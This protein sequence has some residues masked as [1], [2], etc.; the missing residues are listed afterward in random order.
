MLQPDIPVWYRFLEI[1]GILFKN[2]W[3]DVLLGAT[4]LTPLQEKDP[5]RR[6]ERT[7]S[8]RRADAVTETEREVW[9]IEVSDDPGLRAVGQL[10][11]YGV[12]WTRDPLIVKPE[13][14]VLVASTIETNL[15]DAAAT[16]GI[17][18]YLI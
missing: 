16:V 17:R 6:M 9:I 10:I 15:L 7:L 12:L 18:I 14:L 2:L 8:S 13:Q 4:S 3:Y 5:L 1:Y 11:S